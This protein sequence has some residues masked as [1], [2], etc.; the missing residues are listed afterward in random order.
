MF[1]R[2]GSFEWY[3]LVYNVSTIFCLT[4]EQFSSIDEVYGSLDIHLLWNY[5]NSLC[6]SSVF[7]LWY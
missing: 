7:A 3:M 2:V 5:S 1:T 6:M 4:M